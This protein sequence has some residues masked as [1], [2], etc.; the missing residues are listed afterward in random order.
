MSTSSNSLS[1]SSSNSSSDD[2]L[3]EILEDYGQHEIYGY[4]FQPKRIVHSSNSDGSSSSDSS[5]Y[6]TRFRE[7]KLVRNWL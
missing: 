4:M 3:N 1:D 2:I 5:T 6:S 7:F